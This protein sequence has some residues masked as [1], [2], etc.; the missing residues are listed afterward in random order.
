[1]TDAEKEIRE[2]H[3]RAG[4]RYNRGENMQRVR[5]C[6][7]QALAAIEIAAIKRNEFDDDADQA[8]M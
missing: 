7:H 1:M 5:Q 6:L 8:A 3:K 2:A 4:T